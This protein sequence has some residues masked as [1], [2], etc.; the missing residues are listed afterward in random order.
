MQIVTEKKHQNAPSADR[1]P[2]RPYRL[3][4]RMKRDS[5][6][7]VCAD[8]ALLRSLDRGIARF[9]YDAVRVSLAR[10]QWLATALRLFFRQRRC[11][12]TREFW[13]AQGVHVPP[14]IILSVTG[15]CNLRCAGC[16]DRALHGHN[17]ADLSTGRIV[18]LLSE[19]RGLGVSTVLIAGGE[20]LTRPDIFDVT[21]RF[22]E[23]AFALFTN[24]TLITGGLIRSIRRQRNVVPVV[25]IEGNRFET[26][27]RRGEGVFSQLE[28]TMKL[29]DQNGV[30][31]G[32]AIT[33]TQANFDVVLEREWIRS[34]YRNG[35]RLFIFVE[36]VPV[37]EN[38]ARL[39]LT[40]DQRS[41]LIRTAA[42]LRKE[43]RALFIAFPG[44]E[45]EF[46]GCLA[47]GRGFV[48]ISPSGDLE[49]CPFAP[50]SDRN[51]AATSLKRALRSPLLDKI[52]GNHANLKET[53]GGCALWQER[54]WVASLT[55][56]K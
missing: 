19:A 13:R 26:D 51:V 5:V 23:T 1:S 49:P 21:R 22:P 53:A 15:S 35:C 56:D 4:E 40:Q 8:Q 10:P 33:V 31:F 38:S 16:Y 30:L 46:G 9:F 55:K 34:M 11:A 47:A 42:G 50:Y 17:D 7:D 29:L 39:A 48:H 36:Y 27:G 12:K 37:E 44:D 45:D 6:P 14:F 3:N 54:E 28:A 2:S 32:C 25:S 24:G 52:R 20:P 18:E 41:A 43:F